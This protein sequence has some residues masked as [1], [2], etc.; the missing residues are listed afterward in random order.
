MIS[1]RAMRLDD[2]VRRSETTTPAIVVG[3]SELAL[4][5][6]RDLGSERV[7]VLAMS[8]ERSNSAFRSRYCAAWPCAD[9]H[10]DEDQLI[11][12]LDAVAAM[13][14][15]RGVLLPADDDFSFAVSRSP[16]AG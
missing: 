4:G 1:A 15:Q 3:G 8:P 13:L 10:Y 16:S 12:D 5:V 2:F 7:P 6:V 11:A 9:P 14:P